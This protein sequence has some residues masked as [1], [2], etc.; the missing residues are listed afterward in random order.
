MQ[1][2]CVIRTSEQRTCWSTQTTKFASSTL[3]AL[4]WHLL[5]EPVRENMSILSSS[6][7]DAQ[8]L[9]SLSVPKPRV[10]DQ[11]FRLRLSPNPIDDRCSINIP[12]VH[13]VATHSLSP[14]LALPR[15]CFGPEDNLYQQGWPLRPDCFLRYGYDSPW[16][17]CPPHRCARLDVRLVGVGPTPRPSRTP[18]LKLKASAPPRRNTESFKLRSH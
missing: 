6:L 5:W 14:L 16:Y 12:S 15:T 10:Q 8:C 7:M 9:L 17:A 4:A 1:L 11:D 13:N 18:S 3:T 2:A